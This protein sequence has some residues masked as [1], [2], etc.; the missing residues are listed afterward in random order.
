MPNSLKSESRI[1]LT[2]RQMRIA[3]QIMEKRQI[4]NRNVR[5]IFGISNKAVLDQI[6]RLVELELIKQMLKRR[7]FT[8]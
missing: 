1:A 5:E 2:E 6:S 4:T 7:E 3:E 8:I